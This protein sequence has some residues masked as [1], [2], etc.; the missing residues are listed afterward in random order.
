MW[1]SVGLKEETLRKIK[2][3]RTKYCKKNR[4]VWAERV[5]GTYEQRLRNSGFINMCDMN[6]STDTLLWLLC[7]SVVFLIIIVQAFNFHRFVFKM[8]EEKRNS[9]V[10]SNN[11]W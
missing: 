11:E 2:Q 7:L 4:G 6:H 3:K 5:Y 1:V 9:K 8:D 10:Q